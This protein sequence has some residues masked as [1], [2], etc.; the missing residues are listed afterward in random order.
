MKLGAAD[1]R[2]TK[3]PFRE[4]SYAHAL[5]DA[6]HGE[7][8]VASDD[9]SAGRISRETPFERTHRPAE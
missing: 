1:Y 9:V 3:C 8:R 4:M 6:R 2:N 7:R 5:I